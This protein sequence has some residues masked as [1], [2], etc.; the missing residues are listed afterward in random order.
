[1]Y[2]M[3]STPVTR[4]SCCRP[5]F[6][7]L[8]PTVKSYLGSSSKKPELRESNEH[9]LDHSTEEESILSEKKRSK[10][11]SA[12]KVIDEHYKGN[13]EP[14][15][16]STYF[17]CAFLARDYF[18]KCAPSHFGATEFDPIQYFYSF[19]FYHLFRC[20]V[21]K[22]T[23]I[24]MTLTENMDP[25][26]FYFSSEGEIEPLKKNETQFAYING[27]GTLTFNTEVKSS[28]NPSEVVHSDSA[29]K[30][31]SRLHYANIGHFT[32]FEKSNEGRMWTKILLNS[33]RPVTPQTEI[34][35]DDEWLQS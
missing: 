10:F 15:S 12:I 6:P 31:K 23:E 29:P 8:S 27:K 1:M 16:F 17:A 34:T 22:M 14:K 5:V 11:R 25:S 7:P 33:L 21:E 19:Q 24:A 26:D 9:E 18:R 2:Y 4:S 3:S 32:E 28:T 35:N 20:S 30:E 13:M